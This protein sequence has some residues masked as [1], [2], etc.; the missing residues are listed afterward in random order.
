MES[1]KP[2]AA[3]MRPGGDGDVIGAHRENVVGAEV[4]LAENLDIGHRRQLLHPIVTHPC[5]FA[6]PGQRRFEGDP[7]PELAGRLGDH[8]IVAALSG[9]PRGLQAGW[10]G[11]DNKY[12]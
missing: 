6:E 2:V 12:F 5:P 10:A 4:A 7:S 3:P 8:D 9:H 1:S 11:A